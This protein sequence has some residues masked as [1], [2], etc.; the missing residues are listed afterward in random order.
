[1]P[2]SKLY[3]ESKKIKTNPLSK[4]ELRG[5]KFTSVS[6]STLLKINNYSSLTEPAE[7][8]NEKYGQALRPEISQPV[9]LIPGGKYSS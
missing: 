9:F 8:S 3:R 6:Q 1:M 4:I 5:T 7:N 2:R